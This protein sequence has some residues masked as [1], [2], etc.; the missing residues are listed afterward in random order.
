MDKVIVLGASGHARSVVDIIL[1]NKEYEVYGL[2]AGDKESGFW[3]IDVVGQDSDLKEI[4]DSG[5]KYAFVAIGNNEIREKI[6][7]TL[8]EIGYQLINVISKYAVISPH[9]KLETGIVVMPGAV[10]NAEVIIGEGCI[11]NTNVSIDHD[12]VIGKYSHIAP[13][14]AI[15]GFTQIG[16]KCFL[17]TGTNVIDSVVIEDEVTIGAGTVVIKNIIKG[18]KVVGVP[19]R[20]IQ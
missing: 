3:G 6:S 16:R 14:C 4:Y 11:V 18:S 10:L 17:G 13:G 7:N 5:I 8:K 19:A 12:D 9:A 2:V 15:S 20:I 1:Q